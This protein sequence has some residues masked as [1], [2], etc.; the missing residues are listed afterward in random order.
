MSL[1]PEIPQAPDRLNAQQEA[2]NQ[3]NGIEREMTGF[4]RATLRWARVAVIMSGLAALFVCL[5]WWEMR[6]GGIDTH[7]LATATKTQADLAK[8]VTESN[9]EAICDV[10]TE[11]DIPDDRQTTT[12][13]NNGGVNAAHVSAHLEVTRNSL[14]DLGV[15]ALIEKIDVD[16]PEILKGGGFPAQ[17][18]TA[19]H[20]PR[21]Q[22]K[23]ILGDQETVV[24][25]GTLDY[26]N[27]L[28]P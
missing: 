15:L 16:E 17:L 22:R 2:T 10:R 19:L 18:T 11:T 4:E 23:R 28:E 25:R 24:V 1:P 14:P 27:G 9:Y 8:Q 3:L 20:L 6:Q 5:Q 7:T 21:D 13:I 12:I 26:D